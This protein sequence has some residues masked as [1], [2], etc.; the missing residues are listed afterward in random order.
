[1]EG[2][3]VTV[4][5]V[6]TTSTLSRSLRAAQVTF[7]HVAEPVVNL[8][9]P[10]VCIGCGAEPR[11]GSG[12]ALCEA[13]RQAVPCIGSRRCV[14]CGHPIGPH[15]EPRTACPACP[16]SR[17]FRQ[18]VAACRYEGL[19]RDMVL[20]LKY[21]RDL[22]LLEPLSCLLIAQLREEPFMQIVDVVAPVPL[23]WAGRLSRRF[24]QAEL[25]ARRVTK[26]FSLP[27]SVGDFRRIRRT[28]PQ[29]ELTRPQREDNLRG[30]FRVH[31]PERLTGRTV[32]LV[33]DV[34]TTCA[35]AV[36][37]SRTLR[38]A[39][40]KAVYVAAVARTVVDS[41]PLPPEPMEDSRGEAG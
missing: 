15:A 11:D 20:G 40:A 32:L 31:R 2:Q 9:Y 36:E 41:S 13:C 5:G 34:V 21:A 27:L 3:N 22:S 29:A 23:Y 19:V 38:R 1:M 17:H 37:C 6:A 26:H 39:G 7:R 10:A 35:T 30:A 12:E 33:D 8:L 24:N 18:A 28:R 4:E 25:L 16:P 14:R